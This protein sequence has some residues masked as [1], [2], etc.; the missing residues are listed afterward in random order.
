MLTLKTDEFFQSIQSG[1]LA[2]VKELVNSEPTLVNAKYNTDATGILFA[3]YNG[4]REIAEFLAHRKLDLDLFEAACLGRVEQVKAM[5]KADRQLLR[6]YSPEGFT[7]L[8]LAA[9]LGQKEVAQYLVEV[10][11]DVNATAKNQTGFTALTGAV[12]RGH[13]EIAEVLLAKGANV[14][15]R[16]E[17]GFS[18][19]MIAAHNGNL[20]L[21]R[22]L[23]VHGADIQARTNDGKT[24]LSYS[25]ENGHAQVA[26]F[27]KEHGAKQ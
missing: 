5:V 8:A 13:K 20:E 19:L 6:S 1:N 3:L 4:H 27:L 12:T 10:G 9:Y 16:Y 2:K 18:P 11:A 23:L 21:T 17:A 24:A 22:L 14:N 26:A 7:A 25:L 15:H